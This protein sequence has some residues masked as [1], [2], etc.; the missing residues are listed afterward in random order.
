MSLNKGP[1]VFLVHGKRTPFGKFG[2]SL[3]DVTPVDL[4]VYAAKATLEESGIRPEQIDQVILGNVVPSS[5]DTLYGGRHLALKLGCPE[6]TPGL[7][8]NRLCGSGIQSILDAM[9]LV[10]LGEANCVLAGGTENM[11]M[12]PHLTYGGRFG[13]KYG[14]LKNVD[15]L[16]DSLTDQLSQTPMGVTAE[17]LGEKFSITREESDEFSCRSH[18]KASKAYEEGLLQD[19]IVEIEL[20]RGSVSKDEHLR[21][22]IS[23]E[24]MKKLRTSFKK[25]G[26]VTPGSASGIVDGAATV[27]VASE[28][29]V[30]ENN[31]TPLAELVDGHVVGVDPSIMGIGPSPAV[32]ELMKRNNLDFSGVDLV[33]INEAF[34]A[35]TLSCLKDMNLPEDKLNV[36]GGAVALGHPLAASGT[37]ITLTLARQLKHYKK[38]VGIASACIGGGQGIAILIKAVK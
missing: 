35:Q 3:K 34:S 31:L 7:V 18:Q 29:F 38:N 25:D 24:D 15:M 16:L 14:S 4:A 30:K 10:K 28:D 37:R 8:L 6:K 22:N 21:D 11:S 1:R 13:T 36:W 33:E 20:K 12:V 5:T 9:R 26:L 2:G 32:E 23:I 27:I 19:E 17:N